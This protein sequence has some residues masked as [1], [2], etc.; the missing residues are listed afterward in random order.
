MM[1]IPAEE[2]IYIDIRSSAEVM[3]YG[4]VRSAD[5][6]IP[7]LGCP[8]DEWNVF[9]QC[10]RSSTNNCFIN[11]VFALV[12]EFGRYRESAIVLIVKSLRRGAMAASILN[13]AGYQN[14][15]IEQGGYSSDSK[16][17]RDQNN[18]LMSGE[19]NSNLIMKS[20]SVAEAIVH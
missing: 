13:V 4:P 6:H 8:V 5:A 18:N 15:K 7:Y 10:Y 3:L 19:T 17:N 16:D 9:Q 20:S 2:A 1:L 12:N 14:V 11:D